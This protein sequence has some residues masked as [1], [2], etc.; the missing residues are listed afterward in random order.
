MA[1][2]LVALFM[3]PLATVLASAEREAGRPLTEVEVMAIR[4]RTVVMMVRPEIAEEMTASRGFRDVEPEDCWA[5]WHRLRVEQ[6]GRG[7]L[8]K[9]VL[10][11]VG[12]ARFAAEARA[13]LRAESVEHE[14]RG[15][16]DR[17]AEAFQASAFRVD[18]S[19]TDADLAAI[20]RHQ[21]AVY[22]LSDS[23]GAGAALSTT[24][25]ML[26]LGA[27]LLQT[28]GAAM[29]CES[30]GIAHGRQRWLALAASADD[31]AL[32]KAFVQYPIGPVDEGND[33][34]T[35]GL[36]LLGR[37]DLI[38][39][40]AATGGDLVDAVALFST[41]ALYL[42]TECAPGKFRSGHTFRLDG[43]SPRYVVR[44]E[45]CGGYDE[46]DFFFNPFGR[47][48]FERMV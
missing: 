41:F 14:V 26:A 36:H 45:P 43:A 1:P 16:D 32:F 44:W 5:D 33:Y 10:C 46:D 9:L 40:D 20:D 30:S 39:S 8:P 12:D 47:Y 38:A 48:R 11:A 18:R 34:Y 15:H 13:L 17:M 25:R 21:S 37:P 3:P 31:A 2:D 28:G 7:Y 35:C 23:F 22:F 27:R 42:L 6:T 19:L 4:D 24:R 29:K